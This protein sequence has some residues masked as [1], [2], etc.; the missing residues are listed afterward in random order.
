MTDLVHGDVDL[1]R[2]RFSKL[3]SEFSQCVYE[4]GAV[5]QTHLCVLSI[6]SVWRDRPTG[7]K[8][9]FSHDAVNELPLPFE[10]QKHTHCHV[11]TLTICHCHKC[12][13]GLCWT[14]APLV[15]TAQILTNHKSQAHLGAMIDFIAVNKRQNQPRLSQPLQLSP[16]RRR[17]QSCEATQSTAAGC[18]CVR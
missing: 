6:R 2:N 14:C 13:V 7:R 1:K 17:C 5:T 4:K 16:L 9:Q 11:R 15:S 12:T 3:V 8:C 10:I 18:E